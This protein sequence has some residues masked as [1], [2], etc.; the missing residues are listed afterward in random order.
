[1]SPAGN[2]KLGGGIA[3]HRLGAR[4]MNL[5]VFNLSLPQQFCLRGLN[6]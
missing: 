3:V 4:W 5:D 6:V 2:V 1:M